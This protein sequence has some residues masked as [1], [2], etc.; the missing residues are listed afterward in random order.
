MSIKYLVTSDVHLGHENTPTTHIIQSFK[1]H[2]LS[3]IHKDLDILFISGDLFDR[4]LDLNS[5]EVYFIIEFFNYLL[6][7]CTVN[8]IRLRV[9]EGTPSHD[10]G[11]SQIL[12]KL[13]DIR[14]NKCDLK[15]HKVL[16]IEY[17]EELNHHILYIPDEWTNSHDELEQQ[18][19]VKLQEHSIT[20]VDTAILHGQFQYQIAGKK[21]GGFHY[22]EEYFL[23]LIK[24]F[25]HVGHYH[26]YTYLDRII[27]NG[28]LERLVHGEEDPKGY[29]VVQNNT[30]TFF[31]N[32]SAYIYKTIHATAAM[33]LE[34]LDKQIAKYPKE[35]RIRILLSKDHPFNLIFSEIKLRYLDYHV[36]KLIKEHVTENDAATYILT[37]SELEVSDQF[38]LDKD[39][40]QTLLASIQSKHILTDQETNKL[41]NYIYI[42]KETQTNDVL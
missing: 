3:D 21:Y 32:T 24:G 28:S 31:E 6:S 8:N 40:H 4:L 41:L 33:T 30:Y 13:N 29:V 18:I 1:T 36:K 20:K 15:Y 2:I 42:F 10:W 14:T 38:V 11:Q 26:T 34:R 27:A 5:K 35:S 25:I 39:I 16:D 9:L 22:K 7:Y 17:I 37:D 12:V 19:Q 23:N